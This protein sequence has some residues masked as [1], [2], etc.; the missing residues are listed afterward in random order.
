MSSFIR[1]IERQLNPSRPVHWNPKTKAYETAEPRRVFY[2]G[3]GSKLGVSN[4]KA[5][6][7]VAR[8][9]RE[10]SKAHV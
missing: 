5:A 9:R 10:R 6:D 1:R 3:R 8:L 7:L 4:P 2:M